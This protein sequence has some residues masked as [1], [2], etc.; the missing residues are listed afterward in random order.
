M[1]RY[2]YHCETCQ[3]D[4]EEQVKTTEEIVVCPFCR[5]EAKRQF[6]TGTTFI[7]KGDGWY[8]TDYADKP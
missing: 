6:P 1:P 8:K 3:H 2:D 5:V 4:F 7:L